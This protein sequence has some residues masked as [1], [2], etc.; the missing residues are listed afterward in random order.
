MNKKVAIVYKYIPQYRR[1]FYTKLKQALAHENIELRVIYGQPGKEDSIKGD[2]V[3]LSWGIKIHNTVLHFFGKDIYWQ[4]ILSH[5]GDVDLVIVEQASK[6]LVNYL[7]LLLSIL[8]IKRMALWGHG[9]NFQVTQANHIGEWIKSK[10]SNRA[11]WFFAYTRQSADIV[12]NLGYS[13]DR[14]TVVQNAIDTRK[15]RQLYDCITANE[16]DSFKNGLGLRSNH[17]GLFA[18]AMYPEKELGF[19]LRACE[20]IRLEI[21]D[22]EM[23]FI[24]SGVDAC[25]VEK[26]AEQNDWIHYLGPRFDK[27]KVLC[28]AIADLF[29]MPGAVGL[30]ILDCFALELPLVTSQRPDHGPEIDYLID[31]VNGILVSDLLEPQKYADVVCDLL[32]DK[33]QRNKLIAGCKC[34]AENYTIEQMVSNFAEGVVQALE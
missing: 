29:L 26:S 1:E 17:I 21:P 31:G 5:I 27:E 12:H 20:L 6:L 15:L 10:L 22:F 34:S 25:L 28:F 4:P 3:D 24:G 2:M 8:G 33:N 32:N 11:H 23:L 7:L 13:Y 9:K 30:A 14:I 19:L 18:G 16:I